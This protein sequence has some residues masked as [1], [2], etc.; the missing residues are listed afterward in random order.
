MDAPRKG[1]RPEITWRGDSVEAPLRKGGGPEVLHRG[2]WNIRSCWEKS[3]KVGLQQ[4]S[5]VLKK[6]LEDNGS[7]ERALGQL[8]G[9][10]KVLRIKWVS[11][12]DKLSF[13]TEQVLT[14][15][16]ATAPLGAVTKGDAFPYVPE[17]STTVITGLHVPP[18]IA[19]EDLP[20][21]T[22]CDGSFDKSIVVLDLPIFFEQGTPRVF[23]DGY[24]GARHFDCVGFGA[25]TLGDIQL[26]LLLF[27]QVLT[28]LRATAPLGAVTKGDAFPYVPEPST[29]VITGLHVPPGIA[30]EDLPVIT[31]CDGSFDKSIVVLDL[32]I[33][34]EQGTPRV[35]VDGYIGARHFDC[36]GFGAG[37]LG[38]IQLT[39]LLFTQVLTSLRATAPLGAVT[40]G[41]A[42]PYV[43][44]PSTTVITGL[45]VPPGI[46]EEDLPVITD[47]DGSFD[48]S[49]VVLDLPIFFEQGTPRVFVDGYIGARHFD[50]V[51][52]GAGTLG[53]MQLT[54]LLFTQ[55]VV[56][57]NE[58]DANG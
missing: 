40:K 5:A 47:C 44:E 10:V 38:D 52:F 15:L 7:E 43:P 14:S 53:D 49:I 42:F 18:G 55:V 17:P 16:R 23:V 21:I 20:V 57:E 19:E 25:G 34:F 12:E 24:I 36:V 1:C 28:S 29:T 6:T 50:C 31:D 2:D 46:A 13:T 45:H 39:L 30:E 9:V 35:F 56:C 3:S 26:T 32:P 8:T 27:T 51:G 41:D 33:F 37:T 58:K 54:L 11:N 48:K 4:R 22:D